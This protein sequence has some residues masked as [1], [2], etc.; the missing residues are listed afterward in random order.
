MTDEGPFVDDVF[1]LLLGN[2]GK[3]CCVP[4][5]AEGSG[6]LLDRLQALPGFDNGKV[7]EA[8][9]STG[10]ARFVCWRKAG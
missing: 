7:I 10:N 1:F 4:P 8:M 3:G 2:D 9:G 5:G 6:P